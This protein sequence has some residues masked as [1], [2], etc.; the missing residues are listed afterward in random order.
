M[1]LPLLK[2]QRVES[3]LK[4]AADAVDAD[5]HQRAQAVQRGGAK[6]VL[7]EDAAAGAAAPFGAAWPLALAAAGAAAPLVLAAGSSPMTEVVFGAQLAPRSSSSTSRASS[8]SS[9]KKLF[10][11]ESTDCGSL[12]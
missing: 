3:G 7:V 12:R 6:L 1:R 8:F 9:V 5:Q 10:Q 2:A 4:M 11:L